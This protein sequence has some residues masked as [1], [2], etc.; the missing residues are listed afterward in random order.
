[1]P[2][3]KDTM[4]VADRS[5]HTLINMG[6]TIMLIGFRQQRKMRTHHGFANTGLKGARSMYF[7]LR[8]AGDVSCC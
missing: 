2:L 6:K 1:M 5:A 3:T 8:G 4:A 7:Q